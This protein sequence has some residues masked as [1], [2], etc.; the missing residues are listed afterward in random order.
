MS[1]RRL[2]RY[3]GEAERRQSVR[4][5]VP[6]FV[7][8]D[9]SIE[10]LGVPVAFE[11]SPAMSQEVVRW[12]T[13]VLCMAFCWNV[14]AA[15]EFAPGTEN[16][17]ER[18][19]VPFLKKH[20]FEC[21]DDDIASA[22]FRI[23]QLG[24]S[25]VTAPS[26]Y[27]V[28]VMDAINLGEM[29]PKENARPDATTSFQVVKWI[30]AQLTH[31]EKTAR[32]AGG[33]VPMRRLNRDEFANTVRDLLFLDE[34][35]LLPLVEDLPGDGKAE[36]FDRLGV[37]LF[38]DQTQLESTL[39][40]AEKI[41]DLAIVNAAPPARYS[42]HWQPEL[43]VEEPEGKLEYENISGVSEQRV[44]AGAL[45]FKKEPD[46][47]RW[48]HG[49]DVRDG[50]PKDSPWMR[51]AWISPSLD[52]VV[53]RDGYYRIR[54]TA[55][56][57]VGNRRRDPVRILMRYADGTPI[58][59]SIEFAIDADWD[60][61]KTIEQTVF[62]R[63]GDVQQ[64]LDL[65]W[66][67]NKD[68]IRDTAKHR[69]HMIATST[70]FERLEEARSQGK[71]VTDLLRKLNDAKSK[72]AKFKGPVREI[73]GDPKRA[74]KLFVD[75]IRIDGPY[76]SANAIYEPSVLTTRFEAELEREGGMGIREPRATENNRF[77]TEDKVPVAAGPAGYSIE[78]DGVTFL[79]G[80]DTYIREVPLGRLATISVDDLITEDGYYKIRVRGGV[81]EGTRGEPITLT[82][83]YNFKTPQEINTTVPM[84]PELESPEVVEAVMFL[85]RGSPDQRRKITLLYNDL[86]KYIV[87]TPTFNELFQA[88]IGTVGK[89]QRARSAGD[90][91]EVNRLEILLKAARG[92]A[93]QWEGPVRH[94]NP[95]YADAEPPRFF[96]DWVEIEGPVK[97]DW[98]PKSHQALLF[99]GDVTQDIQY[100]RRIVE[101]FLPR[102][103]R[104]PVTDQEV[105]QITGLIAGEMN[106]GREFHDALRIGLQRILV[107]PAFLFLQ[108]PATQGTRRLS[109]YELASRLSYFLWS[110]MPDQQ[111]FELASQSRLSS[112]DV[113]TEQVD[114]MLRDP[115]AREFVENFAG[116]WLSVRDFGSVMPAENLYRD[117]DLELEE[118]SKHEVFEFFGEVLRENLS[119]TNFLDSDFVVINE[120]LARH[121]GIDGVK[122]DEFRQ[123]AIDDQH[124]RGG[125]FGMAGLMTLLADGTRTLPVRRGAWVLE[126][127]FN[128][129]PPPPPPNAGEVQPNTEG[130]KLTVRERLELHRNEATCASCHTT[131]DPFGLALEN[132]DAIGRWR[133]RQNGEEFRGRNTPEL[134]VSGELPSGRKFQSLEEFKVALLE[135]KDRFAHA[136]SERMMTYALGRPV[137]YSDRSTVESL[138]NDLR[139][140]GYRI[141]TLI[142]SIVASDA[143]QNK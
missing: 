38:F 70:A 53:T 101:R 37:A 76:P 114:R 46:G 121:Y 111:L 4:R 16:A 24:T 134:D 66:N 21:H 115:K 127:L 71:D 103:Y 69:E 47:V 51:M 10:T 84:T 112:A 136:F 123:V 81:D 44:D 124:H 100:A 26:A 11:R 141:Q 19:V 118:S 50:D 59:Q 126:N 113:L 109:D 41:A 36:G 18:T 94:I 130:E 17:Y 48:I 97:Q 135:E 30:A 131:L 102:A 42:L 108:E 93:A 129:P 33:Q 32:L 73:V 68:L 133:T 106:A 34:Q 63:H 43:S 31:S 80:K 12:V 28:E 23:S 119:I 45:P 138:V 67:P 91:D 90:E 132:Y 9:C 56:A 8:L 57:D 128:D 99:E 15:E 110:S 6:S 142:R 25:F 92:R 22:G 143:F 52:D 117:Y 95:Q 55:A 140:D 74:P 14:N 120:R 86:R 125:V 20:C 49:V 107:S 39:T 78:K 65:Y 75:S 54:V 85:R 58:H 89:I 60:Q 87:S 5:S 116:Q 96:L 79:Q 137:G 83:S 1:I 7:D 29:P 98:P 62:L 13:L 35:R 88:T 40:A 82:L 61:P 105:N 122:G 2:E 64:S 72:A 3:N 77:V 139:S 27:W 104:R